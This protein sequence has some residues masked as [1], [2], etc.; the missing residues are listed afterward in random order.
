MKYMKEARV[1]F[2]SNQGIS[3]LHLGHELEIMDKLIN[4]GKSIVSVTCDNGLNSCYFNP[5]NNLLACALCQ[6][7][8]KKNQKKLSKPIISIS[9]EKVHVKYDYQAVKTMEELL[10]LEYQ[11]L[12]IG[13]GIA[14]SLISLFREPEVLT[15]KDIHA[16]IE[17]NI[18]MSIKVIENFR[19]RILEFQ[20]ESVYIFNGRFAEVHPLVSL[21]KSIELDFYTYET[22]YNRNKYIIRKNTTVHNIKGFQKELF[23]FEN[24]IPE[25]EIINKA[26]TI[27][28]GRQKGE[29]GQVFNYLTMQENGSLPK[30]F[31]P[32]KNN[33]SI[34]NSSEDEM[35]V[36]ADWV[37]DMYS[38]QGDAVQRILNHYK[39]NAGIHFYVRIH[40]NLRGVNNSQIQEIKSLSAA[41]L[42]I[43]H[44]EETIDTYA[45]IKASDKVIT[46]GSTVGVEASFL[47]K[48]SILLGSAFYK[49]LGCV[50]EPKSLTDLFALIDSTSL[51]SKSNSI[52]VFSYIYTIF[53]RGIQTSNFTYLRVNNA[54]FKGLK[55]KPAG[56]GKFY[57]LLKYLPG[58]SN[59]RKL[60]LL[61]LKRP[62]SFSNM[63][64]LKSHLRDRTHLKK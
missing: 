17:E 13:R 59:W 28:E 46:F 26:T 48:P 32:S 34:F 54:L 53:H 63:F 27:L 31:D 9:M 8:T 49:G 30:N 55:M 4:E 56:V 38:S 20:P 33:V 6:S 64:K 25:K 1:L 44:A 12:N 11:G 7:R 60:T 62:L 52:K 5:T 43:I 3:T 16:L 50:F 47:Q 37:V 41:N 36:I 23:S 57:Y 24:E 19:R 51:V 58:F 40:P 29:Q 45:L 61:I 18:F 10:N 35:K 15:I 22:A 14:S 2:F 21:C 39:G 42:T